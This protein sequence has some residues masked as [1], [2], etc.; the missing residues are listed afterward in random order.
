MSTKFNP[1][2]IFVRHTGVAPAEYRKR[3]ALRAPRKRWRVDVR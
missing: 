1:R 2:D 3:H